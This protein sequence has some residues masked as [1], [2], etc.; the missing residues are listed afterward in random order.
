MSTSGHTDKLRLSISGMHC[1]GCSTRLTKLLNSQPY[2]KTASVNFA[3]EE[4]Q[5]ELT[6]GVDRDYVLPKI[7]LAMQSGGFKGEL[8]KDEISDVKLPLRLKILILISLPFFVSMIG[9]LFGLHKLMLPAWLQFLLA[10]IVQFWIALPFYKSA[11]SS[12]K[13]RMANMDVLV[14]LGTVSIYV[15]S[16]VMWLVFNREHEV[17]FEGSVMIVAFVSIGKFLETRNKKQSL[18][19]LQSL[20]KLLPPEV[21]VFR[22]GA[23]LQVPLHK[24]KVGD[25]VRSNHGDRIATDGEVYQGFALCNES[26]LT[27]ESE[28]IKK[29]PGDQVSAGALVEDGSIEYIATSVGRETFLGDLMAALSEAQGSQAP[30]SRIA[31]RVAGVFVPVV[32]AIALLTFFWYLPNWELGI[33]NAVAV[34]VIACPCALG[35]ATP[36]AMMVGLGNAFRKG[37]WV[38]EAY[39]LESTAKIDTVVFDKTGTLTRGQPAVIDYINL[40]SFNSLKLAASLEQFIQHPLAHAIVSRAYEEGL[41]LD[42]AE[43]VENVVGEG[44]SASVVVNEE[45]LPLKVGSPSFTQS[46]VPPEILVRWEGRGTIICISRSDSKELLGLLLISD[47]LRPDS[48]EVIKSLRDQH[49]EA[50][51]LSGDRESTVR[52][53]AQQLG[54]KH[55]FAQVKPRDKV[56]KIKELQSQGHVVAMVGDGINDAAALAQANVG[57][58]VKSAAAVAEQASDITLVQNNIFNV[59]TA[60][61]IAKSTV[62]NIKQNLFF[63]LI[64][65]VIGI[66]LAATGFLTPSIAALCMALSSISVVMNAM[67]LKQF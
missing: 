14:V 7:Q 10:T 4:A 8:Q 40:G 62:R 13:G 15:Y 52:L 17:Y 22:D 39:T 63:A 18:N 55:F 32:I 41:E 35:L 2:V 9:M 23:W 66:P 20:L 48:I 54:I 58:S 27:G 50:V 47:E 21:S 37:I 24:V 36:A 1:Q 64:Y 26:H 44:A 3:S 56:E 53:I 31:D 45:A 59:C 30:I 49:V 65:N 46:I 42:F 29:Q 28:L 67:R 12:I 51:L 60:I 25:R 16:V 33:M 6:E 38:K 57:I 11:W 5:I 43:G 61:S 19:S 34:L